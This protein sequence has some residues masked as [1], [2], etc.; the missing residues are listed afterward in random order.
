MSS[1][2][3]KVCEAQSNMQTSVRTVRVRI[4]NLDGAVEEDDSALLLAHYRQ[5]QQEQEEEEEERKET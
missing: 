1:L 3:L 2:G 5:Q 4:L